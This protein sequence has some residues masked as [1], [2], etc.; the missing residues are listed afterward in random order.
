MMMMMINRRDFRIIFRKVMY[1]LS[2]RHFLNLSLSSK[3][4]NKKNITKI[5]NVLGEIKDFIYDFHACRYVY[6]VGDET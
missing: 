3:K 4:K 6:G 5:T 2:H 1:D